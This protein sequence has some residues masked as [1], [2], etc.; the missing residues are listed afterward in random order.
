MMTTDGWPFLSQCFDWLL[1]SSWQGAVLIVAVLIAQ[2]LLRRQLNARWRFNLWLLV[3]VRLILPFSPESALS[4]FNFVKP[5]P[6]IFSVPAEMVRPAAIRVNET[7]TVPAK[8]EPKPTPA[9]AKGSAPQVAATSGLSQPI[10]PA[11]ANVPSPRKRTFTGWEIASLIWLTGL[12][13]LSAHVARLAFRTRRQTRKATPVQDAALVRLFEECRSQMG[14]RASI[15]LMETAFVKSPALCG[16]FRPTLLL[17]P[18]LTRDFSL[19]ELRYIFLHELAHVKRRDVALNWLLTALQIM[20]W[21]N[22]VVWFGFARLRAD[23]EQ[24]CDAL[25]IASASEEEAKDYGKTVI[26]LLETLSRPSALPGLVGIMEDRHQMERRIR[27]IAAFKKTRRWSIPALG[28]MLVLAITGLTDAVKAPGNKETVDITVL[29]AET[30]APVQGA[31]IISG[32]SESRVFDTKPPMEETDSNGVV[33]LPRNGLVSYSKSFGV[34]AVDHEPKAVTWTWGYSSNGKRPQ[35][36]EVPKQYTVKLERGVEIGGVVRDESGQPVPNVRVEIKGSARPRKDD[37]NDLTPVEVPFYNTLFGES[38]VTDAEGRWVCSHFPKNIPFLEF[39]M[40]RPDNSCARFHTQ[41]AAGFAAT[42]GELVKMADLQNRTAQF[43]MKKG[44]EVRGTVVDAEGKPLAGITLT[45][46]DNRKHA[47][48]LAVL[49][50]GS[51]GSFLLPNRDPHQILLKASGNGFALNPA[52]VDIQPGMPEVRI[53]MSP[54]LPLRVRVVNE[55]GHPVEK[56][57][58]GI[59]GMDL[60]WNGKSDADGR[61][62][63]NE[64]PT[65]PLTYGVSGEGYGGTLQK[66]TPNGTEQTITFHKGTHPTVDLTVKA[67]T[68]E[69]RAV[70]SFTIWSVCKG[71]PSEKIG[72]GKEGVFRGP[73]S[74]AQM[75]GPEFR[76][77]VE[78][79]GYEPSVTAPLDNYM[80]GAISASVT[81]RK[82]GPVEGVVLLPDGTP[83]AKAQ[84]IMSTEERD[85]YIGMEFRSRG[86]GNVSL[87]APEASGN[88]I[89]TVRADESGHFSFTPPELQKALVI[90][91][92]N[93]FLET[94]FDRLQ[95]SPEVRLKPWGRLEGTLIENGKPKANQRLELLCQQRPDYSLSANYYISTDANGH[96]VFDKVP[97]GDCTLTCTKPSRGTWSRYHPFPVKIVAGETTK[98]DYQSHGRA[99]TGKLRTSPPGVEIDWSKAV[100]TNLLSQKYVRQDS[101]P[102]AYADFI[103]IQDYHAA[104][105][106][107]GKALGNRPSMDSFALEFESDGSFYAEGIPP[108]KYE[109]EVQITDPDHPRDGHW[110]DLGSIKQEVVVPPAP[111]GAPNEIANLG[112]FEMVLKIAALPKK[113]AA[114]LPART[115]DGKP[116]NLADYRGKCVLLTFWSAW[117]TPSAEELEE[118]KAVANTADSRLVTIGVALEENPQPIEGLPWINAQL[119]G[120]DKTTATEA[121]GVDSLPSIFLIGPDGSIIAR[122]LK[123][124]RL[125]PAVDDL[126][127]TIK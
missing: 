93:G 20:H 103:R 101:E 28:V 46:I 66:I 72:K 122:N 84:F 65:A 104:F 90:T 124:A 44:V 34:F 45:E 116:I 102:P 57:G 13:G 95:D 79:S 47:Q 75:N 119:T 80:N 107:W 67:E 69:H 68:R 17:P 12:A 109:L 105:E 123:P 64:A 96:F 63:W 71:L 70:D 27:M 51:D 74:S 14:V 16:V 23:R 100:T 87:G 77:K 76:L 53:Q 112:E 39:S 89:Q 36:P 55:S 38:P 35:F 54:T 81:L 99:V 61:I 113:P 73:I 32:F 121:W 29:D 94:S 86:Q 60:G 8:A 92:K 114:P 42:G 98:V 83:A 5:R 18:G 2:R 40:V 62:V 19:R 117:A 41:Q 125:R 33:K 1:R 30:G 3:L 6:V 31:R 127:K 37:P 9:A 21:F 25:A 82:A 85:G 108:G 58:M 111:E 7:H 10:A 49:T 110:Q 4:V 59:V 126:L 52:I 97:P 118:L 115:L 15:R 56:A 22:P 78:A 11:E 24:A 88:R 120:R 26:K 106:R 91:H 48:P 50:T 43:V